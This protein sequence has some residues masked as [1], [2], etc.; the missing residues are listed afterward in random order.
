[1]P[2]TTKLFVRMFALIAFAIGAAP[3]AYADDGQAQTSVPAPSMQSPM[4][5]VAFMGQAAVTMETE[6]GAWL[7]A[8]HIPGPPTYAL[9]LDGSGE[10]CGRPVTEATTGN[11]YCYRD[12]KVT[13]T[14][15]GL[16]AWSQNKLGP[17]FIVAHETVHDLQHLAGEQ[18][19]DQF[20]WTDSS[21]AA[22]QQANCGAG[23]FFRW[24]VRNKRNPYRSMGSAT[25]VDQDVLELQALMM[26]GASD[27][28][29]GDVTGMVNAFR[30]GYDAGE[31]GAC[32][33][34]S[35]SSMAGAQR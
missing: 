9:S 22:E 5:A 13:L 18:Y 7:Q 16:N 24:E 6:V 17:L 21:V 11:A 10:S 2:L 31:L 33:V 25:I 3:M 15:W 34:L 14:S 12:R 26:H 20:H 35:D 27:D 23:V 29:H 19:D 32:A 8:L 30:A 4:T 1:M 28:E